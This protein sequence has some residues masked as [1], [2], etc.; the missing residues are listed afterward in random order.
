MINTV[1]QQKHGYLVNGNMSVPNDERN[2]DFLEVQEFISN[3]GTVEPEFTQAEIDKQ[4]Q[5]A[6]NSEALAYLASTDWYIVREAE[7][8]VVCPD[9]IKEL[10]AEA[11]ANIKG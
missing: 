10:R 8:G 1:K 2:K 6:I 7:S 5:D 9:E 3:G 4:A 11:R